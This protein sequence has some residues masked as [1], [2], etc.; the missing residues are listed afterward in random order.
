[1]SIRAH[2][3]TLFNVENIQASTLSDSAKDQISELTLT[4]T[5][6]I[7]FPW[8]KLT[9]DVL[10]TSVKTATDPEELRQSRMVLEWMTSNLPVQ[11]SLPHISS[12]F[13]NTNAAHLVQSARRA[14]S[15]RKKRR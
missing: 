10:E 8:E 1:L 6:L 2:L 7:D 9:I 14:K 3:T 12:Y 4:G 11:K 15:A 13:A 5:S